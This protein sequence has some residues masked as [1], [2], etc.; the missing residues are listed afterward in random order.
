ME[1]CKWNNTKG[2]PCTTIT[3]TTNT[4]KYN[5][6]GINKKIFTK[7]QNNRVWGFNNYRFIKESFRVRLSP[8]RSERTAGRYFYERL[9][10]RNHTLVMLNGVAINDQSATNGLT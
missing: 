1:N 6:Q 5:S 8:N 9:R 2:I 7:Q 3:K 10:V 4:S